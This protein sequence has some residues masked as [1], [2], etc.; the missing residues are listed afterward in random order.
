M[1]FGYKLTLFNFSNFCGFYGLECPLERG[2][3]ATI[4]IKQ[5]I[6]KYM[7]L[8]PGTFTLGFEMKNKGK[9]VIACGHIELTTTLIQTLRVEL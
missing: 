8:P 3:P 9:A 6:S 4:R 1:V 7:P 2:R 5:Y